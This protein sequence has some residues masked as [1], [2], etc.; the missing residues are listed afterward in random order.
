[1]KVKKQYLQILGVTL[2]ALGTLIGLIF[3]GYILWGDFEASFFD[4]AIHTDKSFGKLSCPIII[5]KN[6]TGTIKATFSN[7]LERSITPRV[8]THVT[9]GSVILMRE[10]ETMLQLLPGDQKELS[11]PISTA[12]A[13]WDRFI[14]VRV[15]VFPTYPVP[16]MAGYCGT[17][18]LNVTNLTGSQV[19]ILTVLGTILLLG[20]G[21]AIYVAANQ[22]LKG[23][24]RDMTA[25]MGV[26]AGATMIGIVTSLLGWWL[27]AGLF[28]IVSVIT[29]VGI[30]GYAVARF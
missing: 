22:P 28:F 5:T 10:E 2:F 19:V 12:D 9:D 6:E 20:S 7:P 4:S 8:R 24:S 17:V 15:F 16:A 11:W 23:A 18:A 14:F 3:Y 30:V 13:A 29:A 25:G 1:M 26:L 27:L 21:L